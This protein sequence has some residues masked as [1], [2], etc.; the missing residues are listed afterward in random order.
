[1]SFRVEGRW[2]SRSIASRIRSSSFGPV[3]RHHAGGGLRA[4]RPPSRRWARQPFL[5]ADHPHLNLDLLALGH[6]QFFVEF[7]GLAVDFSVQCLGHGGFLLIVLR[8]FGPL[9]PGFGLFI[10]TTADTDPIVVLGFDLLLV[11]QVRKIQAALFIDR[12]LS[13]PRWAWRFTPKA[14]PGVAHQSGRAKGTRSSPAA[15]TP[16][17]PPIARAEEPPTACPP[18]LIR[19]R[20]K[21]DLHHPATQ[22]QRLAVG[23]HGRCRSARGGGSSL[24]SNSEPRPPVSDARRAPDQEECCRQSPGLGPF[25]LY[26]EL[27]RTGSPLPDR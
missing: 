4:P 13:G 5:R 22:T 6:A 11:G 21:R 23:N 14:T 12:Q 17:C 7:D 18:R 25:R 3:L 2:R 27:L 19:H 26:G 16:P 9:S 24:C 8:G 20:H 15:G 10:S 1:R